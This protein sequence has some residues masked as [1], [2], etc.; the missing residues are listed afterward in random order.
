[1][2]QVLL[3]PLGN[4]MKFTF[5]GHIQVEVGR[6]DDGAALGLEMGD[7]GVG[8]RDGDLPCGPCSREGGRG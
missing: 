1:M 5:W 3:N 6:V 7:S 8:I 4:A 2:R